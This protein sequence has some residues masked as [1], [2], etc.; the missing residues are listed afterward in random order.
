MKL[1][2]NEV[3]DSSDWTCQGPWPERRVGEGG[4]QRVIH[5]K[6]VQRRPQVQQHHH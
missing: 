4:Q 3:I 1:L 2:R 6:I 5:Q